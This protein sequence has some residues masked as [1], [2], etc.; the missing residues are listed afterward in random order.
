MLQ[1]CNA[2]KAFLIFVVCLIVR[3]NSCGNLKLDLNILRVYFKLQILICLIVY[4]LVSLLL[5]DN[6]LSFILLSHFL[7]NILI[8]FL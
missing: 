6:L 2:A 3:N 4:L 7:E 8:S 1:C 5:F